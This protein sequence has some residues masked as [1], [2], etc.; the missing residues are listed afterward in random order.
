[1]WYLNYNVDTFSRDDQKKITHYFFVPRTNINIMYD[2]LRQ[3][4]GGV[5]Q[6]NLKILAQI[7]KLGKKDINMNCKYW[8]K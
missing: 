4:N 3:Y 2:Y 6:L 7:I 1:M 5:I 8:L